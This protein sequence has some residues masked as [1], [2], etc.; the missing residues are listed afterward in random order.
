MS[1]PIEICPTCDGEGGYWDDQTGQPDE[2]YGG[3]MIVCT[4][5]GGE[6]ID[7]REPCIICGAP[8]ETDGTGHDEGCMA[9]EREVRG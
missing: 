9:A 6:G 3:S 8:I 7:T 5:C 4:T 1:L 2:P